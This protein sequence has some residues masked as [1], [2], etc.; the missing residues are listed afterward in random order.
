VD[1]SSAL[2]RVELQGWR[3]GVLETEDRP[4]V[5]LEPALDVSVGARRAERR[6]RRGELRD[7]LRGETLLVV[8][9]RATVWSASA[10][11]RRRYTSSRDRGETSTSPTCSVGMAF[12]PVARSNSVRMSAGTVSS[13][14]SIAIGTD[15]VHA[16]DEYLSVDALF[17]NTVVY[18]RLPS[19]WASG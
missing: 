16:P 6:R 2:K 19:V 11:A 5:E 12:S 10:L 7:R 1:E 8:P 9:S 15:T 3:V 18:A 17:D 4:R 13:P 14:S